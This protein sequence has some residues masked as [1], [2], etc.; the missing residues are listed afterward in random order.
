MKLKKGVSKVLA[1]ESR[2]YGY[3]LFLDING[4]T[5][6]TEKHMSGEYS[7]AERVSEILNS[8]FK[9]I[10]KI[11]YSHGGIVSGFAGDAISAVFKTDDAKKTVI[12]ANEIIKKT[13]GKIISGI[14]IKIAVIDGEIKTKSFNDRKKKIYFFDGKPFRDLE[15]ATRFITS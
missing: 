6:L 9:P 4:F 15:K 13:D 3:L 5:A 2:F 7:G 14:R 8:I 10:I 1:G 11:I 12:C